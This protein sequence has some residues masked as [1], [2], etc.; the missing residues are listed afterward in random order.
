MSSLRIFFSRLLASGLLPSLAETP[1]AM[2]CSR[3]SGST[4]LIFAAAALS[5]SLFPGSLR[6]SWLFSHALLS[7]SRIFFGWNVSARASM[8]NANL[9][10]A[11]STI[12][13]RS[14]FSVSVTLSCPEASARRPAARGPCRVNS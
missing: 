14:A 13:P 3:R 1:L 12:V 4:D 9:L 11:R 8:V 2:S 10:P 6:I 7:C 5:A